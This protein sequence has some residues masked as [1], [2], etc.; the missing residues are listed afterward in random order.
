MAECFA[1]MCLCIPRVFSACTVLCSAAQQCALYE[2]CTQLL[3]AYAS[4][5]CIHVSACACS[6]LTS[7]PWLHRFTHSLVPLRFT[8]FR[9]QEAVVYTVLSFAFRWNRVRLSLL[10]FCVHGVSCIPF[11][12]AGCSPTRTPDRV[13][14]SRAPVCDGVCAQRARSECAAVC[15]VSMPRVMLIAFGTCPCACR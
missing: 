7:A 2:L 13:P 4:V 3:C 6:R 1:C 11:S 10:L 14:T 5:S 15:V 9:S 8:T 12:A